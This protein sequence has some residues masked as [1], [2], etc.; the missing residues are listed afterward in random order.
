MVAPRVAILGL[1]LEA[2][3][4]APPTVEADFR[5][6]CWAEGSAISTQAR[7]GGRNKAL[8]RVLYHP[9]KRIGNCRLL[10]RLLFSSGAPTLRV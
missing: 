9:S 8:D 10:F 2:N 5:A 6:Q 7:E 4:F 1:H 3:G